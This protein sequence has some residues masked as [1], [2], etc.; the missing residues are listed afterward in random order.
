MQHYLRLLSRS[1]DQY[2]L[3][4]DRDAGNW[5]DNGSQTLGAQLGNL[6]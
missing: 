5:K 6:L 4:P 2:K 3:D 1:L